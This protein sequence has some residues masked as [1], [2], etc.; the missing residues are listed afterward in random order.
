[1]GPVKG[2]AQRPVFRVNGPQ[3][4]SAGS[5]LAPRDQNPLLYVYENI[6]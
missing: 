6:L 3:K 2:D 1:M 4:T 5:A